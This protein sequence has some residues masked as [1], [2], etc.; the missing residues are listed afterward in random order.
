ML[1]FLERLAAVRTSGEMFLNLRGAPGIEL[2][3][4]VGGK[5][6][7]HFV[8]YNSPWGEWPLASLRPNDTQCSSNGA[9]SGCQA[10]AAQ[11]GATLFSVTVPG[12]QFYQFSGRAVAPHGLVS[13][14]FVAFHVLSFLSVQGAVWIVSIDFGAIRVGEVAHNCDRINTAAGVG[15]RPEPAP[16]P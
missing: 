4:G 8:A 15:C 16:D 2:V 3:G 12:S 10:Q 5:K 7:R 13:G 6:S 11:Q 9:T 14:L 1:E